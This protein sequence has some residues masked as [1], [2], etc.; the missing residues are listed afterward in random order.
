MGMHVLNT[1]DYVH[2]FECAI[3]C[4]SLEDV[5]IFYGYISCV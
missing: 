2:Q 3:A 4:N 5:V 1:L